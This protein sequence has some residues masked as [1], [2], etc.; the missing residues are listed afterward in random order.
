MSA[1]QSSVPTV[2]VLELYKSFGFK[3]V[4]EMLPMLIPTEARIGGVILGA[5]KARSELQKEAEITLGAELALAVSK[6]EVERKA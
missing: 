5:L 4:A 3:N 6:T 2:E 1:V